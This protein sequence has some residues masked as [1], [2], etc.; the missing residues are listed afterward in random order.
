[1]DILR[2]EN[3]TKQ[4][5][6]LTAV[7]DVSAAI[8]KGCIFGLIGPNGAGKTTLFNMISGVYAPTRGKVIFQGKEIQGM[9]PHRVNSMGI[10]RT[11]QNINLF[12]KMTVL[13]NVLVGCHTKTRSGFWP[14]LLHVPDQRREESAA[15][16]KCMDILAFMELA[17]KAQFPA[18]GLSYGEQ[19]RLEIGRALASEPDMLLL[20]EPAAGMNGTEKDELTQIIRRIAQKGITVL[21]VEH[22]MRLV[23]NVTHTICVINFGKKIAFG[24]PE[25]IQKDP[26]V[27]EAYLGGGLDV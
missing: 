9:P 26:Q 8:P 23:M 21:L 11:Y 1:M 10:A 4:F 2:I 6:G 14:S 13:E 18:S 25:E 24:T 15:R 7:N 27:I 12:K 22:D 16:N 17:D 3:L 5:G 20:D 19:R